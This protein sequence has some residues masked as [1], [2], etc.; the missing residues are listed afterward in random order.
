MV[1][2]GFDLQGKKAMV[3]GAASP[4]G[5]AIA[6]ALAEAGTDLVLTSCTRSAEERRALDG[7]AGEVRQMGRSGEYAM[8]DVAK[9]DEVRQTVEG[10]IAVLG[11]VDI[12]VNSIDLPF[13]KP[14]VETTEEEWMR[15]IAVN[16]NGVFHT[17]K[18][19]ALH[20]VGQGRG[21]IINVTSF[22]GVR[23][24]SN[25]VAYCVAKGGVVQFTKAA[26]LEWG[27]HGIQVTGIGLGW[28]EGDPMAQEGI[29]EVRDRLLRYLPLHRLGLPG[30]VGVLA[31]YLASEASAYVTGHTTFVE[32]GVMCHV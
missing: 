13:A 31:V 12:L 2:R 18:H 23:G 1:V 16:L 9:E 3:V 25:A 26:A 30:E 19:V 10:A 24:L 5:H 11:Q 22:L 15:V 6:L 29:P 32:G 28:M 8:V 4:A 17:T 27:R 14:L 21:K 7:C 20:M